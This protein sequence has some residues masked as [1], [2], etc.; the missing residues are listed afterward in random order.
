M[1]KGFEV[2][3]LK[4]QDLTKS[5]QSVKKQDLPQYMDASYIKECLAKINNNK[6]RML[7][8]FLW[9]TGVRI[10]EAVSIT[11]KDIDL[12]NETIRVRWLKSRKYKE[13]NIP[14][15]N[16]L[17]QVLSFYLATLKFEDRVFPITRQRADQIT[18]KWL[19][20]SPH[21]LR[22][23]FAVHYLRQGGELF[24]LYRLLGH[25]KI[26]TTMEYLKIVPTDLKKELDKV[27]F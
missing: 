15:H 4:P 2:E 13:R 27:V 9:M 3:V 8:L 20:C 16:Q 12:E 25:K 5:Y 6:D 1:E 7:V 23:S 19:G 21:K 17:K 14:L 26:Q 18:K 11:R 24:D 10:T 22:H